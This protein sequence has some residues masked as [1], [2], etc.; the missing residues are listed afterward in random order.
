MAWCHAADGYGFLLTIKNDRLNK[1]GAIP[2]YNSSIDGSVP[3][4]AQVQPVA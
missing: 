4:T 3:Q 2:C 1:G